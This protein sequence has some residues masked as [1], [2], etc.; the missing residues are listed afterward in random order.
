VVFLPI[1]L[2]GQR[3]L[4]WRTSDAR[5]IE[6]AREMHLL[7]S[8]AVPYFNNKV[9]LEKP[10]LFFAAMAMSF[11]IFGRVSEGVARIPAALFALLGIMAA[12]GIGNK[13]CGQRFGLVTGFI[14]AT[15]FLYLKRGHSAYLD[16]FLAAV[17][18]L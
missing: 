4:L 13:L 12:I 17:V 7:K 9:F 10:P 18:N 11:R 15:T 2:P 5:V 14:M 8:Y 6:I 16:V 3:H 1:F